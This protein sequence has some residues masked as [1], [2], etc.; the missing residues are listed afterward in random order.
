MKLKIVRNRVREIRSALGMTQEELAVL[1]GVARQ[2]I[3]SIEKE[4]YMPNI[5]TAL[6]I[7][8]S[9]AA[10]MEELFWLEDGNL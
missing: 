8:K 6:L 7:S 3:I 10:P 9:L 4:R 1:T 2:S 5:E